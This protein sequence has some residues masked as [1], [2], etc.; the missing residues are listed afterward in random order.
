MRWLLAILLIAVIGYAEAHDP[1][2]PELD[3]WFNGLTSEYAGLCCSGSEANGL[4]DNDWESKDGHYRIF[5][6]G[7]W[8]DVPPGAVVKGPNLD[9][10]TL[11]WA[12]EHRLGIP[13]PAVI[14]RCFMPGPMS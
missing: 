12:S 13:K 14:I 6:F 3:K 5:I 2:R 1:K 7:E 8:R 4:A 10:R 9:G 11:V